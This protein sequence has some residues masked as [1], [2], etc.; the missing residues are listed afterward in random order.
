MIDEEYLNDLDDSLDGLYSSDDLYKYHFPVEPGWHSHLFSVWDAWEVNRWPMI[1]VEYDTPER[2]FYL[3]LF[4]KE[5]SYKIVTG[6]EFTVNS[7]KF[8][9]IDGISKPVEEFFVIDS[10]GRF[11]T[12]SEKKCIDIINRYWNMRAFL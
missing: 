11:T 4:F 5:E 7:T 1:V 6:M 2:H 3:R 12:G 8:F 9:S 10:E